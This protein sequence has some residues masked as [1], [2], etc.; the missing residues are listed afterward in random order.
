MPLLL[1]QSPDEAKPVVFVVDG[2]PAGKAQE[3]RFPAEQPG[4]KRMEGADPQT[5]WIAV[6]QLAN[7]V[8]HLAGGV[9][10]KGDRENPVWRH[11]MTVDEGSD[12]HRQ[13]SSLPRTG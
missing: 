6:E 12:P 9:V 11:A 5:R 7:A 3:L 4:G 8:F 2:K 10:G 13:D 1:H